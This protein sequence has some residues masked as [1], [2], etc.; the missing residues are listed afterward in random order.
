MM[1]PF[2]GWHRLP[3]INAVAPANKIIP[4]P[5]IS[6]HAAE[7]DAAATALTDVADADMGVVILWGPNNQSASKP[8]SCLRSS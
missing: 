2:P 8:A 5:P 4:F 7:P 3:D 1:A 6:E